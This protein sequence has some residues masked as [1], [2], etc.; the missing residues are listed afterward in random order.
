MDILSLVFGNSALMLA[1]VSR[2]IAPLVAV[3]ILIRCVR[4]MLSERYEPE[5][6]AYLYL[7]GEIMVPL[8][9]WE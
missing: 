3:L 7:P 9:H 8:R 5:T 2:Y 1:R 6:W 4:S